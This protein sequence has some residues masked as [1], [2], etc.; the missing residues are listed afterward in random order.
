MKEYDKQTCSVKF[1]INNGQLGCKLDWHPLR[2]FVSLNADD[3]PL[4][5]CHDY[6]KN[7]KYKGNTDESK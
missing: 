5:K 1:C 3:E 4:F 2:L 7:N 6:A